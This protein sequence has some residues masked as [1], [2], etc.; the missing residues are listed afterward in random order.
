MARRSATL[1][2]VRRKNLGPGETVLV[3]TRNSFYAIAR[4]DG[5]EF[6]VS[7]G[8]FAGN[9]SGPSRVR[10]N[11]CTWG[12]RAILSEVVA[13]PGLFLEFA[14]GI[15]TTRIQAVS[16]VLGSRDVADN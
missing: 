16:R 13:A 4:L 3:R 11:G 6:A 14:N 9:C 10:I 15:R 1:P 8:W 12:R 2:A 5:D 7:G